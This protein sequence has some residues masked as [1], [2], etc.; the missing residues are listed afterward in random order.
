MQAL[1]QSHRLVPDGFT[2]KLCYKFAFAIENLLT[3][4]VILTPITCRKQVLCD[5]DSLSSIGSRAR[6]SL[7]RESTP[8]PPTFFRLHTFIPHYICSYS[9]RRRLPAVVSNGILSLLSVFRTVWLR[10]R[11]SILSPASHRFPL[12]PY[13]PPIHPLLPPLRNKRRRAH[14]HHPLNGIRP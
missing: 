12:H 13:R 6:T 7:C 2:A 9:L 14:V 11:H 5:S 1:L 4:P 10:P 3:Q 8:H